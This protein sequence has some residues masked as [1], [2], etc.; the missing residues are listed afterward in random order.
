MR[1]QTKQTK[2]LKHL[3]LAS[4][5]CIGLALSACSPV[6]HVRGNFLKVEKIESVAVGEDSQFEV[7]RKLGSPTTKSTFNPLIWYYIGQTTEKRG[8][9]DHEIT[10]EQIV[11]VT[12]AKRGLV[13]T[14]ETLDTDRVDLPYERDK[15]TTSG[16][17]MTFLQQFLGNLGRF[18]TENMQD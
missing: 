4:S 18:N 6:H 1:D 15:T 13:K 16:N 12:F 11:R 9:L 5:M 3:L 17:E 10:N 14:V 7:I 8:I 2:R